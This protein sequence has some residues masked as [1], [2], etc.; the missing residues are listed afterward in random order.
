[1]KLQQ[2]RYLL[3]I[4]DNGFNITTA[5]ENLYTSQP[6]ISKQIRLLE[7]EL[8]L[9]LFIRRGK[10][11][12]ALTA[13]GERAVERGRH[14]MQ[15]VANIKN[16][17][18]ELKGDAQGTLRLGTTHTQ[19]RYVLPPVI[20]GFRQ[21]HPGVGFDIHQGTSDQLAGMVSAGDVD[22]VMATSSQ[23][24]FPGLT[25]LPVY[26]WDRVLLVPRDHP[27][28]ASRTAPTLETLSQHPLV[29][30]VFSDRPESSLSRTFKA[31]GL[32]ANI[33][34]TA[35]DADVIKTYVRMGLGVGLLAAM[36]VEEEVDKDL[37]TLDVQHLFPRLTTWIGFRRD[38][39]LRGYQLD[40][41]SRLAPHLTPERVEAARQA[42]DQKAVE[43]LFEDVTLPV[44][45]HQPKPRVAAGC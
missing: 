43:T 37:V 31:K 28:A 8:G 20:Q 13:A 29:T 36:A 41:L 16:L 4:V 1:M 12:D 40:F 30:Y 26:Q 10:R 23:H 17:A 11:I 35:R 21:A 14:I 15:E 5:A 45:A 42:P 44:H 24:L 3:A 34:F 33:G 7:D 9:Q 18:A 32:E 2:I 25:M 19:A 38:S 22:F 6:G 27:L 39:L